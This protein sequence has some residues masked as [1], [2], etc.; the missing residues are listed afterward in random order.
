MQKKNKDKL[1]IIN[2]R[3]L[4]ILELYLFGTFKSYVESNFN[5]NG[6]RS[7]KVYYA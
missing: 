3:D 7:A 1:S 2:L 6:A 4:K 5:K